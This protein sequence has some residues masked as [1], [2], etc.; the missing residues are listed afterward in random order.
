MQMK[1]G[2]FGFSLGSSTFGLK[3]VTKDKVITYVTLQGNNCIFL[4]Q[5]FGY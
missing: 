4:P 3:I 5:I 1:D 2:L